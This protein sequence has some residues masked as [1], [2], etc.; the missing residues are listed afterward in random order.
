MRFESQLFCSDGG[1]STMVGLDASYCNHVT[2]ALRE[3]VGKQELQFAHLKQN[4]F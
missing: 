1:W 4:L 2:T 3:G